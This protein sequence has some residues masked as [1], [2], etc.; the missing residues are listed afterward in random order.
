MCIDLTLECA[1]HL[2]GQ[3]TLVLFAKTETPTSGGLDEFFRKDTIFELP[4]EAVLTFSIIWSLKTLILLNLKTT[5]TAKGFLPFTA[6]VAVIFWGTMA[7]TRRILSM[8]AFFIPSL[9]LF[10]IL[11]HWQA[12]QFPFKVRE[13]LVTIGP[14]DILEL[15]NMTEKVFWTEID[16]YN[17]TN[18]SPPKYTLYTGLSLGQSF[19]VFI[20]LFVVHFLAILTAKSLTVDNFWMKKHYKKFIHILKNMSIFTPWKDWDHGKCTE[21]QYKIK[22][23][24]VNIEMAV[25]MLVNMIISLIMIGP[26][27]YT[28]G[29]LEVPY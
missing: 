2:F 12:E 26:L 19:M 18:S 27:L 10:H 20:G 5:S 29:H 23:M 15:Y 22:H 11:Y 17:Y 14:S 8:V 7:I 16:R 3:I 9:G 1:Y 28:G 21:E 24:R 4:I 25:T 13:S 6:K